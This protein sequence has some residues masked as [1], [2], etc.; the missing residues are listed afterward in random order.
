MLIT[1]GLIFKSNLPPHKYIPDMLLTNNVSYRPTTRCFEFWIFIIF[2]YM[3]IVNTD[4]ENIAHWCENI[5][6]G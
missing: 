4:I 1:F 2:D 5:S 6:N 3:I